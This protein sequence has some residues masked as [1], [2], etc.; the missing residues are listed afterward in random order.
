MRENCSTNQ[1]LGDSGISD[2][3]DENFILSRVRNKVIHQIWATLISY[4]QMH[5]HLNPVMEKRSN[6]GREKELKN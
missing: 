3:C 6:D 2:G 4:L 5:G 1:K